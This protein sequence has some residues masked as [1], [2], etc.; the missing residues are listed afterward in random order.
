MRQCEICG[1]GRKLAGKRNK[2]RGHF[3]PTP[4]QGKYPN[5]QKTLDKNGKRVLACTNCL[6][7]LAK[8]AAHTA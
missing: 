6:K 2:L 7:T 5:L 1:K 4:L 8:R 3:N